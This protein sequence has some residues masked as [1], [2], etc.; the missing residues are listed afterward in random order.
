MKKIWLVSNSYLESKK[1]E[2]LHDDLMKNAKDM[3]IELIDVKSEDYARIYADP[4]K[5]I[6]DIDAVI[7]WD[8]D[9]KFA[10]FLERMGL[11]VINSSRAID[12]CDDKSKTYLNLVNKGI[13]M[14]KTIISPLIYFKID[15]TGRQFIKDA[16]DYL[17][18][19]MV[20]KE[21]Y[22]SFGNQVYLV[23]D[24]KELIAKLNSLGTIPFILQEYVSTSRGKD[25]RVYTL[26]GEVICSILRQSDDGDF[27]SNLTLGGSMQKIDCPDEY[28]KM[29][30]KVSE[31]LGLDYAGLDIMFGENDEPILCEVNSNAHYINAMSITNINIG[32]LYL[33]H[34]VKCHNLDRA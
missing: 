6:K 1:H 13:K 10:E 3:G 31:I 22:G 8:K 16:I 17:K 25:I 26:G 24:E 19:P 32:R 4:S 7:Y 30:I 18:F 28:K 15:W 29:A 12:V 5:H 11:K 33:E 2:L 21:C 14:P 20:V 34:V 23:N 9:I 27:R